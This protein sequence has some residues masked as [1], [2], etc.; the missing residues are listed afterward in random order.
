MALYCPELNHTSQEGKKL[1]QGANWT[2]RPLTQDMMDYAACDTYFLLQILCKQL[3]ATKAKANQ[4]DDYF[5]EL[6][7][8]IS[9]S[10]YK[11]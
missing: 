1:H 2:K 10:V 11:T 8:K 7:L 6:N 3:Q 9:E 4:I 5:N